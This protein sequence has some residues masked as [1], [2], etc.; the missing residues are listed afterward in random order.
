MLNSK[1][2]DKLLNCKLSGKEHVARF[3]KKWDM[4]CSPTLQDNSSSNECLLCRIPVSITKIILGNK[5]PN[6]HKMPEKS[7]FWEKKKS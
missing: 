7:V 2:T 1:Q 4:I 6:E 5:I 3:R